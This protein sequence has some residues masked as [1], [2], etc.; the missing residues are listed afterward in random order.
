MFTF[1]YFIDIYSAYVDGIDTS[2]NNVDT[3]YKYK[4]IAVNRSWR[5]EI[6]AGYTKVLHFS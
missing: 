3:S 2:R 1:S 6:R 4:H 5:M